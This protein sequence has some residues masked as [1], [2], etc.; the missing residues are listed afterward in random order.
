MKIERAQQY[1]AAIGEAQEL[2]RARDGS[3]EYARRQ[4]LRAAMHEYELHL[5]RPECRKGR[6]PSGN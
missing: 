3:P 6:T 4:K 2:D 1:R 5:Q